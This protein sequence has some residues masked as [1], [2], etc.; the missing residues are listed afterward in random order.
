M[1]A[2]EWW[3]MDKRGKPESGHEGLGLNLQMDCPWKVLI[4]E[5]DNFGKLFCFG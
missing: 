4:R 2:R 1:A 5:N 3:K